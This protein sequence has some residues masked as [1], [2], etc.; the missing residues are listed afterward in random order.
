MLEPTE[1]PLPHLSL[2]AT[3]RPVDYFVHNVRRGRLLLDAPY[4]RGSVWTTVQRG[5]LIRSLLMGIP[6]PAIVLNRRL[7][8]AWEQANGYSPHIAAVVDGKQRIEA[9]TAWFDGEFAVPS[10]WFR[11]G[12]L[13][14]DLVVNDRTWASFTDLTDKGRRG[15]ED[16][17]FACVE[18]QV[19]TVQDEAQIYLLVNGAGTAQTDDDM[20][21]AQRV[22][23]GE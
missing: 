14:D 2:S 8:D 22:A 16:A 5:N 20:A 21:N 17:Q 12:W 19:N 7:T 1:R 10:T 11:P 6:V 4:Q 13:R 23:E 3:N 9:M 18:A 15:F